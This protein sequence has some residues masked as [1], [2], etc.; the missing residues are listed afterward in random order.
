MKD[1]DD[2]YESYAIEQA[3]GQEVYYPEAVAKI[4]EE[5]KQ[6]SMT[7]KSFFLVFWLA[8]MLGVGLT[9]FASLNGKLCR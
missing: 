3:D 8:F 1:Y 4:V 2:W 9:I 5:A 6:S 7:P